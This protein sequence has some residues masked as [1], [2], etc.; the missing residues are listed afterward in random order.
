MDGR[1][2]ACGRGAGGL[3]TA[4]AAAVAADATP[5]WCNMKFPPSNV[6]EGRRAGH[7]LRR[8]RRGRP[9]LFVQYAAADESV[10]H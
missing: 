4:A 2:R 3:I 9:T 7:A 5:R 10:G 1:G 8:D 6:A